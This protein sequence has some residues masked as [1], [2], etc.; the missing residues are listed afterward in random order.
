MAYGLVIKMDDGHYKT[1]NKGTLMDMQ[2]GIKYTFAREGETGKP[3]DW[4]VK[5][6]DVVTFTIS[7]STAVSVTLYKKHVDGIVFSYNE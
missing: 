3:K 4:N 7:G 2:T 1:L 6:H 5:L